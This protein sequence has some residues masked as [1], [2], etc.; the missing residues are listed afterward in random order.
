MNW[1]SQFERNFGQNSQCVL[2]WNNLLESDSRMACGMNSLGKQPEWYAPMRALRT[3][4]ISKNGL[5]FASLRKT[6]LGWMKEVHKGQNCQILSKKYEP[7]FLS[8]SAKV[9][10]KW[11]SFSRKFVF[12]NPDL[13]DTFIGVLSIISIIRMKKC[14]IVFDTI[15]KLWP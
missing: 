14:L 15:L 11:R 8:K 6:N 5:N 13:K 10:L 7:L 1:L 9:W 4:P 2:H 12:T 3:V